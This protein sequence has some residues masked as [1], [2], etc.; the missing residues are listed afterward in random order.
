ML[1]VPLVMSIRRPVKATTAVRNADLDVDPLAWH[2][3]AWHGLQCWCCLRQLQVLVGWMDGVRG[4]VQIQGTA[5]A[6][7]I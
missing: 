7:K 2:G 6:E 1:R 4:R 3:M 5:S